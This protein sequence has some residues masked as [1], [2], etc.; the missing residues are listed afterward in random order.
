MYFCCDPD[1]T[2][3]KKKVNHVAMYFAGQPRSLFVVDAIGALS[4]SLLVLLVLRTFNAYIGMTK[5][6]LTLLGGL[7]L[8]LLA[9]STLCALLLRGS[10]IPFIYVIITG[11]LTYCIITIGVILLNYET[12]TTLGLLYFAL[13]IALVF[14]LVS[15]EYVT[16]RKLKAT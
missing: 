7:A 16:A 11:N 5:P 1:I 2:K 12:V 9:Y 3:M 15:L 10:W 4:T 13:E 6:T 14:F 8:C